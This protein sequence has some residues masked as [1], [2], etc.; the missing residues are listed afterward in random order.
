MRTK[1]GSVKKLKAG[2]GWIWGHAL[3]WA[4]K[5]G[6]RWMEEKCNDIWRRQ[7]G[8]NLKFGYSDMMDWWW[9]E[10]KDTLNEWM[11]EKTSVLIG[12]NSTVFISTKPRRTSSVEAHHTFFP[13]KGGSENT[14]L[15]G[16]L[17]SWLLYFYREEIKAPTLDASQTGITSPAQGRNLVL[18]TAQSIIGTCLTNI[19][20]IGELRVYFVVVESQRCRITS[21][22]KL[23]DPWIHHTHTST[24]KN[25]NF[26][27]HDKS[28]SSYTLTNGD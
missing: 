14:R 17:I 3:L 13:V 4:G 28:L 23:W 15:G 21:S 24:V 5:T 12:R 20:N 7:R 27:V 1:T 18:T 6:R 2:R 10:S 25:E 9:S 8:A 11:N 16:S 22:L 19:S 26:Y